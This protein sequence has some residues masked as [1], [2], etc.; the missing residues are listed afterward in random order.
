MASLVDP[1]TANSTWPQAREIA[2]GSG[3]ERARS[4]TEFGGAASGDGQFALI[5]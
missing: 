3:T 1:F 2:L 5:P 4:I